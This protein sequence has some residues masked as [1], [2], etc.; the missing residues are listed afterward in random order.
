M[1]PLNYFKLACDLW[2]LLGVVW[3]FGLLTAKPDARTQSLSS[4]LLEIGLGALAFSLVFSHYF[5]SGWPA[6]SF[7]PPSAIT[8][9]VGLF[10]VL[11]GVSFAIWARLQ[12]GGNWSA[13]VTV[14]EGHT[15][16]CQGP[17]TIVRHPIYSGLLLSLLGV[18]LIVGEVRGLLGVGVFFLALWIKS[19]I[20]E[21]FMLEEFGAEYRSYQQ[22]AKALIPYIF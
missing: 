10:L 14:K 15:L 18:A 2:Y 1:M 17:Y 16:I 12:L 19:S 5:H 3:L 4:R 11:I 13:A 22:R 21:R 6:L 9:A 8:G 20:E 7:A